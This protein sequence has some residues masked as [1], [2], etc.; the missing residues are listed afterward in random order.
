MGIGLKL[1]NKLTRRT[2]KVRESIRSFRQYDKTYKDPQ[3]LA[4]SPRV[5]ELMRKAERRMDRAFGVDGVAVVP[6][7]NEAYV[8]TSLGRHDY[9]VGDYGT[10]LILPA[11]LEGYTA[12][13]V[14]AGDYVEVTQ[15]GSKAKGQYL[16]VVT[17]TDSTHLRLTDY[18]TFALAAVAEVTSVTTVADSAG[19]LNNTYWYL[20]DTTT[21][22]YVWYNVSAGGTDPA[23]GG[24]TGIEVAITTG[25]TDTA[26]ATATKAALDAVSGAW[27]TAQSTNMLTITD[28]TAGA[29]NDATDGAVPT[30][31][32][33]SVVTQGANANPT[34]AAETNVGVRLELSETKKSYY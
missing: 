24:K 8:A 22:Y 1:I 33:I 32:T 26:V 11:N 21:D 31:F 15:D 9:G 18:P 34:P 12:S 2:K 19:S 6:K 13:G 29:A 20:S 16:K 30:G 25:A 14:L 4:E 7:L 3:I 23:V 28:Q 17:V 10:Q 27:T 5:F